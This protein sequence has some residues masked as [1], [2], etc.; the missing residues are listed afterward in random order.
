MD[1][2]QRVAQTLWSGCCRNRLLMKL[3]GKD[4]Q[5]DGQT[6]SQP[7]SQ[8]QPASPGRQT[9]RQTCA[10]AVVTNGEQ[11]VREDSAFHMRTEARRRYLQLVDML[12]LAGPR[13]FSFFFGVLHVCVS[14]SGLAPQWCWVAAP[15]GAV[16]RP[17]RGLEQKV[18]DVKRLVHV[19][20]T[21]PSLIG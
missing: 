17:W 21:S 13:D 9:D 4:R 3:H 8:S 1:A 16:R 15:R 7:A 10:Y 18:E 12:A 11:Q 6:A 14:V 5:A 20:N 19:Y 2:V